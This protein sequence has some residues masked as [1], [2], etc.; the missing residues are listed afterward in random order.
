VPR[1]S[2]L[3]AAAA[4][5]AI[6]GCSLKSESGGGGSIGKGVKSDTKQAASRLGFPVAAT[7]D[8]TRVSGDDPVADA[9]GVAEALF[10]A[11]SPDTRPASVALVD[12]NSWQAGIAAAVLAGDPLHA[13]LLLSDG[14]SLPGATSG[15]LGRLKPKGQALSKGAQVILVGDGPPAPSGFK[16]GRVHGKDPFSIAAAVDSFQTAVAGKPSTTVIVAS[17]DQPAYAMPAAAWAARSGNPVLFVTRNSVPGPTRKAIGLHAK[18]EILLMG[19][20]GI[21][22]P[23]VEAELKK[24]G[25]V[26]RIQSRQPGPIAAAAEFARSSKT[27]GADHPGRNFSLANVSR[28]SD[29]AAAA[30]LGSNGVFAPLLLTDKPDVMPPALESYLLD[31]QPGFEN[32]DPSEAV[33]NRVWILGNTGAVSQAVQSRIDQLTQLVP[34]DKPPKQ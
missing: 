21:V 13:P 5:L 25:N 19:P 33:Y 12:K 16:S 15:T 23:N 10:P 18:P 26:T 30:A 9:A 8:T 34:V 7:R 2:L 27:W 1:R 17:A 6:S 20:P 3:L 4:A 22:S 31:V 32:D 14:G 29:A 24:L 11:S 28:P